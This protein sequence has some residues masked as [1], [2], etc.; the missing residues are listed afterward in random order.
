MDRQSVVNRARA[1]QRSEGVAAIK[2]PLRII[3]EFDRPRSP[4]QVA[5]DIRRGLQ[6]DVEAE[7]LFAPR[8]GGEPDPALRGFVAVTV[9]SVAVDAIDGQAFELAYAIGDAA[10]AQTAEPELGTDFYVV[11]P[12]PGLEATFDV[13]GCWVPDNQDIA[14]G[15]PHWAV[16]AINATTAWEIPPAPGGKA[17]GA[18]VRVFQPDTGVAT[19]HEL[20][21]GMLD[22]APAYD[23]LAN[24]AG[25][26]DP[27]DYSGNPGHGTGT[28]S[29]VASRGAGTIAGSAPAATLTPLRAVESVV[30][31][32]HG[33]VALAVEHARRNGAQV[34]TMSLGGAWSSALRAAIDRAIDNGI[35]VLAAAGNCV[36]FVVWPARYEEVIAVA[37]TNVRG[38]AWR[39]SC[40]GEAV[41]I[42]APAEFVPRAKANPKEGGGPNVVAGG[43]G[44]SFAVAI[45]AGVAALWLGHHTPQRIKAAAQGRPVQELFVALLRSTAQRPAGFDTDKMGAGIVDANALLRAPLAAPEAVEEA[46]ARADPYRSLHTL[47]AEA[48][49]AEA[50]VGA[51]DQRRFAAELSHIALARARTAQTGRL[52]SAEGGTVAV[53]ASPTLRAAVLASG[54]R[55]LDAL[56]GA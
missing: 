39:G 3:L 49:G 20:E 22:L 45:T 32:D 47:L 24:K 5:D 40:K 17:K 33:R 19:H 44:T 7:L 37:G 42:S 12:D 36:K 52:E 53:P 14:A 54:A 23:F 21:A 34:V 26:T 50:A 15:K 56:I 46:V 1:V 10:G 11:P 55:G 28:A 25:A 9:K 35:V 13:P 18:D 27:M 4:A 51:L 41:D 38:E 6:L 16:E 31:F 48:G 8:E 43:Q 29:V 30:V 2:R